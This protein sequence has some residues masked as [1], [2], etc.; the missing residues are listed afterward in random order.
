MGKRRRGIGYIFQRPGSRNWWIKL[1]SP[2]K[3]VVVSLGTSDRRAAEEKAWPMI[4]EH[5]AA[6]L[7]A[8]PHLEMVWRHKLEP[9]RE[10]AGPDGGRI[11]ATDRE[12]IFL[13][14]NGSIIRT[15]PNGASSQAIVT[16]RQ[17]QAIRAARSFD[18]TAEKL[19]AMRPAA[20]TKTGD[21]ALLETYLRHANVTGRFERET[22]NVWA[23]FR[24]LTESKPLRDCDRDDGRKLV[25]H[26]DSQGLA[27]A[28]V[29]KKVMWLRA[30]CNLA[31]DD[32][33][34]KFNPFSKIVP[35]AKNDD[36]HE[37]RLPLSDDDI[38][39]AKRNLDKLSEA[40]ALL[41]RLLAASGM[42]LGEA[43]AI[44]HEEPKEKGCRFVIVG[45]KTPQS[46][47]RVPLPAG[48]LPY[49]PDTIKGPLFKG[50][51]PAASKRLNRFLRDCGITDQNKVIHS[52]RHRAQDRLRAAGCPED[53]RWALLGH[54]K[55][56][57]AAGYG[58][59]FPVPLLKKWIDRIGF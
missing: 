45:S 32:G 54:E 22:R 15:E 36:D 57:V 10:H 53:V 47:R 16:S 41:Y 55:R 3:S 14:H 4:A 37:T 21:D 40:D 5:K 13:G 1:R 19:R 24:R 26:F 43:H 6:L 11:I 18:R 51:A 31:I 20:P 27:R 29:A 17:A 46:K 38:K 58:E 56:T 59:G 35:K 9:G 34:I 23:L 25:A 44:D 52:L 28:T 39:A 42:R 12:L 48:V 30:M 33:K 50:S 49:L 7:A 8:R 2:R